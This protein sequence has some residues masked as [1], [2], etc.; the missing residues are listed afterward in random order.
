MSDIPLRIAA[1]DAAAEGRAD[2]LARLLNHR[3]STHNELKGLAFLASESRSLPILQVLLDNSWDINTPESYCDPPSLGRAIQAGADEDV[4]RWFLVHGANPNA[5][6]TKYRVTPLSR[7]VQYAPLKIVQ[8]LLDFGGSA[9]TGELVWFACQRPAED[10]DALTILELLYNRGAPVDNVLFADFDDLR[11]VSIFT[12]TP[13]WVS[14]GKGDVA[15]VQ[16]LLDRGASLLAKES[17][18]DLSP[19]E[20]AR[21]CV[22]PEIAKIVSQAATSRSN[23]PC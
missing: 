14:I 2:E 1:A 12:G 22:N 19:L 8:L 3:P 10:P 11:D 4:V 20:K 23:A 21:H 6:A 13:L 17:G 5:F 16:F 18:L 15:R 7:A 9:T